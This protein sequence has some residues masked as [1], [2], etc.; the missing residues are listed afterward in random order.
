M[1]FITGES[2]NSGNVGISS[3]VPNTD[4]SLD[5]GT[6]SKRWRDGRFVNLV[7][8]VTNVDTELKGLDVRVDTLEASLLPCV[9]PTGPTGPTARLEPLVLLVLQ[10]LQVLRVL[11]VHR[12]HYRHRN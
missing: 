7:V 1:N 9:G 3:L 10:V 11:L 8:G 4:N 12:V 5:V 2:T 6:S